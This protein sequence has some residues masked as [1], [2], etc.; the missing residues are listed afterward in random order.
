MFGWSSYICSDKPIQP[1][2]TCKKI[3]I[4]RLSEAVF[5]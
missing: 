1:N 2:S 5:S 4:P 3:N